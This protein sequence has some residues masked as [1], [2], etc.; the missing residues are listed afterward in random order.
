MM[1]APAARWKLIC[2]ADS[3]INRVRG[4]QPLPTEKGTELLILESA[5]T[6]VPAS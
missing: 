1:S 4:V 3:S 6:R 5:A 2:L